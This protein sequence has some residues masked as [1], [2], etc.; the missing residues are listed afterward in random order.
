VTFTHLRR[1][2]RPSNT[3]SSTVRLAAAAAAVIVLGP[4]G[5]QPYT[6]YVISETVFTA[7]HSTD[8]DKQN[9]TGTAKY[10]I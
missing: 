10:T 2:H 5:I 4:A 6:V 8:T 9:S 3:A 1:K 7:C